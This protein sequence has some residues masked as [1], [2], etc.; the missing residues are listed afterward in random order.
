MRMGSSVMEDTRPLAPV[1]QSKGKGRGRPMQLL[2]PTFVD[3]LD[4]PQDTY[5]REIKVLSEVQAFY[6]IARRRFVDHTYMII[7]GRLIEEIK[8]NLYEHLKKDL[9]MNEPDG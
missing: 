2:S 5:R 8:T 1:S 4:E 9:K 6:E 3:E 7:L